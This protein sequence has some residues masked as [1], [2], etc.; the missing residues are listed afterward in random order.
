LH[1][2]LT[3]DSR[4]TYQLLLCYRLSRLSLA[5]VPSSGYDVESAIWTP[6]QRSRSGHALETEEVDVPYISRRDDPVLIGNR[7]QI[8]LDRHSPPAIPTATALTSHIPDSE[9]YR[10][11]G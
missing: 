11:T 2:T 8:T 10:T 4:I 6:L 5:P 9:P 3:F 7:L 1:T